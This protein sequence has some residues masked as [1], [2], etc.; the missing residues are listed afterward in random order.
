LEFKAAEHMTDSKALVI[1]SG[2][3]GLTAALEMARFGVHVDVVER[4]LLPGGHAAKL[5]CKATDACVKCGACLI[6]ASLD[7][8]RVHPG[9]RFQTACRLG[10]IQKA[11]RFSYTLRVEAARILADV[12]TGCGIC[13][14]VCPSGAVRSCPASGGTPFFGIRGEVCRY[15]KDL[16]CTLCREKCPAGAIRLE[17]GPRTVAG[18][19]D[20]VVLATGFRTFDPSLKSYGY[21][22]FPNVITNLDLEGILQREGR[23]VRPSDGIEPKRVAFIQ[24]VGS[25]DAK[26]GHLWCSAFCC[27]AALRAAQLVKARR[28]ESEVTVFYIDIQNSGRDFEST[29]RK[30]QQD[31]RFIRAIPGEAFPSAD[32]GLRLSYLDD[33]S[34][35]AREETFEL[36]VLSVGMVPSPES[37]RLASTLG[38]ALAPSGFLSRTTRD[39]PEGV[40]AAGAALGPLSIADA[41]A[42]AR[43]SAWQ[44]LSFMGYTRASPKIAAENGRP[45][46]RSFILGRNV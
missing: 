34:R 3:A 10:A 15:V 37:D 38:M 21:G 19:A 8:A 13:R 11:H 16:S 39:Y 33:S 28:P 7:A 2:I 25:R 14:D 26:L 18:Q 32:A 17:A 9:I 29:Y 35:E 22:I 30:A 42:E 45:L 43:N 44:A 23:A 20:V 4:E 12:C 40:F 5:A 46:C 27:G 1:G 41:V 24:C 6:A 36:V 31:I